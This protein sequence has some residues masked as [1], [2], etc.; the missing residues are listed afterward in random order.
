MGS[1][2][3]KMTGKDTFWEFKKS[4]YIFKLVKITEQKNTNLFQGTSAINGK[5]DKIIELEKPQCVQISIGCPHTCFHCI[6]CIIQFKVIN[7]IRAQAE[8]SARYS[9][10]KLYMK[11]QLLILTLGNNTIPTWTLRKSALMSSETALISAAITQKFWTYNEQRWKP[12]NQQISNNLQDFNVGCNYRP[13]AWPNV[14]KHKLD[15]CCSIV[16]SD[17]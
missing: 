5:C 11:Q 13:T 9:T 10:H 8:L 7:K 3:K 15:D 14:K 6:F 4:W 12:S 17:L 2:R 16:V 1:K